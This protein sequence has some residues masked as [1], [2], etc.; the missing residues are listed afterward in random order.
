[1]SS[2]LPSRPELTLLS[3]SHRFVHRWVAE[4]GYTHTNRRPRPDLRRFATLLNGTWA[5]L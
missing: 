5:V 1:M 2:V 3:H 4:A